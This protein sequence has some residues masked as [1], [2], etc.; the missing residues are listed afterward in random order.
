MDHNLAFKGGNENLKYR[1][2]LGA[3][4]TE[5][6]I[7]ESGQKKYSANLNVTQEFFDH[8]LKINSQHDH[9]TCK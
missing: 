2:S 5:G 6:I 9:F 1:L 3:Q 4:N 8:K 7:K